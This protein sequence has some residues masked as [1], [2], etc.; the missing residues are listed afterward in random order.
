VANIWEGGK[1]WGGL[2]ACSKN[3][4]TCDTLFNL[5]SLVRSTL[6]GCGAMVVMGSTFTTTFDNASTS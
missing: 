4:E 6:V 1:R 3:I 2:K 5:P